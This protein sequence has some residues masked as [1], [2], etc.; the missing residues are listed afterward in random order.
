M[1]PGIGFAVGI[2]R[3]IPFIGYH[4]ILMIL[5]AIAIILLCKSGLNAMIMYPSLTIMAHS[6][7]TGGMLFKFTIDTGHFP[8]RLLLPNIHTDV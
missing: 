6:T 2:Q 1:A 5:I 8:H 3:L 4:H 7:T